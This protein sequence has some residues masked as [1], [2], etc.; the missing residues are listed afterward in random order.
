MNIYGYKITTKEKG[1]KGLPFLLG[2][3][4]QFDMEKESSFLLQAT[5]LA[6]AGMMVRIMGFLYRIPMQ[7]ILQDDGTAIYSMGYSLYML[8]FVMSSAGMPAAISKMV[9]ARVAQ[10][11]YINAHR[12]LKIGLFIAGIAGFAAM[13]FMFFGASF[14]AGLLSSDQVFYS[15][16]TLA[17]TVFIVAIM[18]IFRGYFQGMGNAMPTAI[19]QI[20]EQALKAFFSV[21][22]VW[23]LIDEGIAVAAAGGTAAAAIGAVFAMGFMLFVFTIGKPRRLRMINRHDDRSEPEPGGKIAKEVIF[24]AIPIVAGTAVFSITNIIDAYM[25]MNILISAGFS[26]EDSLVLFGQLAG[27]YVVITTLPV[28]IVTAL[29]TALI[30]SIAASMAVKNLPEAKVK[31]NLALR[32]AMLIAVP[33]AVG[34]GV[35]AREILLFL[36]PANPEG[37]ILLQVGAVSILFLSI[38][39]VSTGILHGL[40]VL[41]MPVIAAALG[42]SIKIPLNILLI[43]MP[44]INVLGAVISTTLCYAFAG[45][46][47]MYAVYRMTNAGTDVVNIFIKPIVSAIFMGFVCYIIFHTLYLIFL[48]NAISLL[49]AIF[50][51]AV[52]Y[53]GTMIFLRGLTKKELILLPMG[54]R[55]VRFLNRMGVRDF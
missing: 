53:F 36:F 10:K 40:H 15:I 22:L 1:S 46:F 50:L 3:P 14:L 34:I 7:N 18:S 27:K 23:I 41:R 28:A 47:N 31:I 54:K 13:L 51:S 25:V 52:V 11:Q 16:R 2:L 48:S 33:A 20:I 6:T 32:F 12:V 44:E 49:L 37:A 55:L 24:T 35:L 38:N 42:A 8:F 39:Q 45:L 43:S 19:S 4:L 17:P 26:Y 30:P 21:F 5:I 9:S 29:S